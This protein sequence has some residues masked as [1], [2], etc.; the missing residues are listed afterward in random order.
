MGDPAFGEDGALWAIFLRLVTN[1][2]SK[3]EGT[4]EP[5]PVLKLKFKNITRRYDTAFSIIASQIAVAATR[6]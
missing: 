1:S 3:F 2:A 6:Q 5:L 4:W